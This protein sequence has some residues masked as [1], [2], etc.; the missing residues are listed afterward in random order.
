M[1]KGESGCVSPWQGRWRGPAEWRGDAG[2]WHSVRCVLMGMRTQ[3]ERGWGGRGSHSV[4]GRQGEG[5]SQPEG[6]RQGRAGECV[7]FC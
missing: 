5:G 6:G 3:C 1:P 7:P 2:T 4:L